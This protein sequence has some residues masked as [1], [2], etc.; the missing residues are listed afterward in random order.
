MMQV[1][2]SPPQIAT[3]RLFW[4]VVEGTHAQSIQGLEDAALVGY[5][6][7]QLSRQRGISTDD[8]TCLQDYIESHITLIRDLTEE[9]YSVSFA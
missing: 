5:F 8:L 1:T 4:G 9:Y 3:L 7:R 2:T 6:L